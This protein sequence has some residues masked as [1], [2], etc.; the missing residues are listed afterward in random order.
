LNFLDDWFTAFSLNKNFKDLISSEQPKGDIPTPHG[1]R[2]INTIMLIVSHKCMELDFNPIPNRTQM[3]LTSKSPMTVVVRASYLYTDSFILLSGM[4]VAY[5]FIGRFQRGQKINVIK[6]IAARYFRVVPPMA[7]LILFGTFILPLL[8]SGPLWNMLITDQ[9]DLCKKNWWRNFLMI[10]N[11]FGFENICMTHT[12]HI[13]TDFGLFLSA[14]FF[15]MFLYKYPRKASMVIF[16]LA[17]A[18]T[19]ARFY[20]TYARD[21]T[22]YVLFGLE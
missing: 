6:E 21:M 22:V 5:S 10:H 15:V 17:L 20:V 8:G 3:S 19:V 16:V 18:S 4:L 14:P 11:W 7:A 2:F 12:H 9:S 1:I 13:G